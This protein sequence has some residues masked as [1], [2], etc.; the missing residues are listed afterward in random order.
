MS[1]GGLRVDFS[2]VEVKN[3][4]PLPVG[5]Y[6]CKITDGSVEDSKDGPSDKNP[7]GQYINFEFTV[8]EGP[9]ADRKTWRNAPI[10]GTGV[11]I[12]KAILAATG[13]FTD[14]ALDG[15]L[16]FSIQ[17][18][19]IGSDVLCVQGK[20]KEWTADDPRTECKR[21]KAVNAT[22]SASN[23]AGSLLP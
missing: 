7:T 14:E 6:K 22:A 3:F 15:P 19:L 13:K 11:G 21:V 9:F 12:L 23:G 8:Q 16:N 17:N 18:D 4:D 5:S 1:D 2:G 10:G 20:H